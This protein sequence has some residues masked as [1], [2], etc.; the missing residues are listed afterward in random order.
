MQEIFSSYLKSGAVFEN[1]VIIMKKNLPGFIDIQ[2]VDQF[3]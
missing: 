2:L 3:K 1:L